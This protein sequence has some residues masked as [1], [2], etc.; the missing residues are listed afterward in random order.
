M[1]GAWTIP[2]L[3]EELQF[4]RDRGVEP[5]PK[6]NFSAS[7]DAWLGLFS[8]RV[9]TPEYYAVCREL[10]EEVTDIFDGPRFMHLGMDEET[11]P[12]LNRSDIAYMVV[13]QK[14]L[15]WHDLRCLVDEVRKAGAWAW[16]WSDV[17]WHCD[18]QEFGRNMPRDVIQSNWYY[19]AKFPGP[20]VDGSLTASAPPVSGSAGSFW[21]REASNA[22]KAFEWLASLG[23]DQV[24]TG[25]TYDCRDNYPALGEYC[26]RTIPSERL[27]GFMMTDWRP[28]TEVWRQ[29]HFDAIDLAGGSNPRP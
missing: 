10:I 14:D 20:G 5:I 4:C 26:L 18:P 24:P 17:I 6:L 29:A 19:A 13:R 21:A 12:N 8:R 27:L 7:H 15:W 9:S 1:Q 16:V 23:Y 11:F 25:S 22:L 3:R 28:M 2:Q